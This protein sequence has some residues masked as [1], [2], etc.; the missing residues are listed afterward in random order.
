MAD[1]VQ[2]QVDDLEREMAQDVDGDISAEDQTIQEQR[3]ARHRLVQNKVKPDWKQDDRLVIDQLKSAAEMVVADLYGA[4]FQL[5]DE[6]Y[7]S[8]RTARVNKHGQVITDKDG[9]PV[10]ERNPDGTYVEDWKS[11][12]GYDI[13]R[14]LLKLQELK[15]VTSQR[16]QEL[17]LETAYARYVYQ[18]EYHAAFESPV[19]GTNPQREA[20]ANRKARDDRYNYL[21]RYWIYSNAQVFEREIKEVARLFE[22]IRQWRISEH[23]R[24]E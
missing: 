16:V 5:L 17:F 4:S 20:V 14:T 11:L 2:Q 19:Q 8:V 1:P 3:Y 13:E 15:I 23:N 6:I 21:Y 12:D 24:W 10:W 22:R 18:D 7:T 9:R